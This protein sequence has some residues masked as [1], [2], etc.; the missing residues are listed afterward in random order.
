[1]GRSYSSGVPRPFDFELDGVPFVAAGGVPALEMSELSLRS[2]EDP[3]SAAGSGAMAVVFRSALQDGYERFREHCRKHGT[4]GDV[5]LEIIRD[6]AE[7]L[8]ET[9]TQPSGPSSPGR[10]ETAGTS[11]DGSR[12]T[13]PLS[14]EEIA[15]W[16][17][18][19]T[20]AETP[21]PE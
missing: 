7:H 9:P 17:A 3:N 13:L 18:A 4:G 16:R 1:M 10:P 19:V 15:R 11:R 6:M 14:D 8:A 2:D 21:S 12:V 5:L 20:A